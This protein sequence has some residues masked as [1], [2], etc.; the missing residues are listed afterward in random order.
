MCGS[1]IHIHPRGRQGDNFDAPSEFV[2][3]SP[4]RVFCFVLFPC[5]TCCTLSGVVSK[6]SRTVALLRAFVF[7]HAVVF[8]ST[9]SSSS[10]PENSHI[11][12]CI[13][14]AMF[15]LITSRLRLSHYKD[16]SGPSGSEDAVLAR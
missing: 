8:L 7:H 12:F 5:A 1:G 4:H 3:D 16:V 11:Y 13:A 10:R 14:A 6:L 15:M 2:R 9:R